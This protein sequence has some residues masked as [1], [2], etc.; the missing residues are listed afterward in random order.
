MVRSCPAH[1]HAEFGGSEVL[2]AIDG[3][4]VMRGRIPTRVR[5]LVLEWASL[6]QAELREA[7][8]NAERMEP[9]G[10]IEPLE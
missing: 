7:W 6:H 1:F 2:V 9:P 10:K 3:P 4:S 8:A 5:R